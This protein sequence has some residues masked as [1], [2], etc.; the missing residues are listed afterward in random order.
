MNEA[1]SIIET[2]EISFKLFQ[3]SSDRVEDL[4]RFYLH[5]FFSIE[6]KALKKSKCTYWHVIMDRLIALRDAMLSVFEH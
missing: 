6:I 5:D 2:G 3:I 4:S 1:L